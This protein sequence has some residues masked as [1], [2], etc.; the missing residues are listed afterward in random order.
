MYML[1]NKISIIE[2]MILFR[3]N[4]EKKKKKNYSIEINN[5]M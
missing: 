4:L 3:K 5:S 1:N 2:V